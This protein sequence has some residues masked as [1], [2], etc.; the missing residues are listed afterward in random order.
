MDIIVQKF[1]G[2]SVATPEKIKAV[3]KFIHERL[4]KEKRI[5]VV[6]S[7]MG[8]ATNELIALAH[9]INLDPPKRELDMLISCGER[10]SMALLAMA[11]CD[12]GVKAMSLT[13]SQSGIITDEH[14]S[15]AQITAIM[16]ERVITALSLHQVVIIAGFQG[17]SGQKEITTLKRGGSDTTAVAM[18]AALN[19]RVCEIYTDVDGVFDADPKI[20]KHAQILPEITFKN[21]ESMSLYGAKVMAHDAAC[22]AEH[23]GIKILVAKVGANLGTVVKTVVE[24]K[25]TITAITHLRGVLRISG[26]NIASQEYLLCGYREGS[27]MIAYAS[28]DIAQ[29]LVL[30]TKIDQGLALITI[31]LGANCLA[32]KICKDLEKLITMQ[33]LIISG[34]EIFVIIRDSDLNKTLN[35]LHSVLM[36]K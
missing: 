3:A 25:K 4:E 8:Q 29:E 13:G 2:T 10:T 18:A 31:H 5:L 14:H 33:D 21:L 17:V 20:V 6:V 7:A 19:A 28:N 30:G 24:K 9:E 15:N 26:L 16:P 27:N 1:G 22:L 12:L 32:F 11:L 23:F 34:K 35:L 36:D